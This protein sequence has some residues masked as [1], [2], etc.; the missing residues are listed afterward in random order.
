MRRRLWRGPRSAWFCHPTS[1]ASPFLGAPGLPHGLMAVSCSTPHAASRTGAGKGDPGLGASW[2][3]GRWSLGHVP[4]FIAFEPAESPRGV[5]VGRTPGPREGSSPFRNPW[6]SLHR[7]PRRTGCSRKAPWPQARNSGVPQKRRAWK[8]LELKCQSKATEDHQGPPEHHS[9][10]AGPGEAR[11]PAWLGEGNT[12]RPAVPT[13][14][15]CGAVS[16]TPGVGVGGREE[17]QASS[18]GQ[19]GTPRGGAKSPGFK[20]HAHPD[21]RMLSGAGC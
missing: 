3:R 5:S 17:P 12:V 11:D 4:Q 15:A 20:S 2:R 9:G 18:P 10:Q 16:L 14:A 6:R 21:L 1:W 7:Q 8:S 19:A 13:T